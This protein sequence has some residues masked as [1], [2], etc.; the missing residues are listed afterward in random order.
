MAPSN[1]RKRGSTPSS[2]HQA[3]KPKLSKPNFSNP[4]DMVTLLIGN[5][6]EPMEP[7]MVHREFACYYSPVLRAAFEGDSMEGKAQSYRLDDI[8]AGACRLLVA[9]LYS[10]NID[11][12]SHADSEADDGNSDTL[13]SPSPSFASDDGYETASS[14]HNLGAQSPN[15]SELDGDDTSVPSETET[16]TETE[17]DSA[18]YIDEYDLIQLWVAADRLLIPSL[19]NLAMRT[20]DGL[21]C[22]DTP[23]R[24]YRRI[25]SPAELVTFQVGFDGI[26]ETFAVHKGNSFQPPLND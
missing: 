9:W 26:T 1:A 17:V 18:Q 4:T 6:E 3:K 12:F 22:L 11:V 20:L 7:F 14:S 16:E 5:E 15:H 23:A 8:S 21:F 2:C 24:Y 25:S 10:Q 13:G 19:Q